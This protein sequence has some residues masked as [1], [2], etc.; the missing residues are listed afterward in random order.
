MHL[1]GVL[2]FEMLE[3]VAHKNGVEV[4]SKTWGGKH[5]SNKMYDDPM[6]L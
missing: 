6:Y 3:I 4:D 1:L 2:I 5:V